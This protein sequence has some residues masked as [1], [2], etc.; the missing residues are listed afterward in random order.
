MSRVALAIA[1]DG[2]AFDSFARQPGHRT[3]EGELLRLLR[4]GGAIRS[5]RGA[6]FSSGSRTDGGVSAAWNVVA[7]DSSMPPGAI[8]ALTSRAPD[9][10]HLLSATTVP[11]SW[12]PRRARSR[13]YRYFLASAWRWSRARKAAALFVGAHDFS[14]F[15][16]ADGDKPPRAHL[17]TLRYGTDASR[18]WLEFRAPFFLW[19]QIRRIVA[20]LDGV[21]RGRYALA[22]VR[23]ALRSP[24]TR[25]DLGIAPPEPLVLVRVDYDAVTFPAPPGVA[26]ARLARTAAAADRRAAWLALTR[27]NVETKRR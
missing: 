25:A 12:D 7:F 20:A 11:E 23:A 6:R 9:G 1:Y 22:Q 2:T 19:Q 3:V 17:A 16:R 27:G 26:R 15:R 8:V 21:E 18:T 13:T 4:A 14:N 10:L 5:V 24:S